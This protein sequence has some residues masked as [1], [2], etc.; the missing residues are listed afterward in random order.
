MSDQTERIRALSRIA[1][2]MSYRE[3]LA[4]QNRAWESFRG[5]MREAGL[6]G[7]F[8]E[9]RA[10]QMAQTMKSIDSLAKKAEVMLSTYREKER[11]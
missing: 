1:D 8:D 2:L 9:I 10:E 11:A 7:E 4:I 5:S 3:L 6:E